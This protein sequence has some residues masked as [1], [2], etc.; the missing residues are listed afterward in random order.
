MD[1][2]VVMGGSHTKIIKNVNW[3]NSSNMYENGK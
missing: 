3:D 2:N 1:Q